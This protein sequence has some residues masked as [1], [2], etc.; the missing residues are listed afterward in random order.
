MRQG[1]EKVPGAGK[2]MTEGCGREGGSLEGCD[3]SWRWRPAGGGG[4][5]HGVDTRGGGRLVLRVMSCRGGVSGSHSRS[6]SG[7]WPTSWVARAGWWGGAG[8][9]PALTLSLL[10]PARPA[11]GPSPPAAKV[12]HRDLKPKNILANSD[13]KLKIC[14]EAAGQTG[15]RE[16]GQGGAAGRTRAGRAAA[17]QALRVSSRSPPTAPSPP[18]PFSLLPSAPRLPLCSPCRLWSGAPRLQRHAHHRVLDRLRGHP[19]VPRA[20]A[21]RLLLRQVLARHRHLV[22]GLHLCRGAAGQA[23]V[24]G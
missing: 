8:G 12:F 7:V 17:G 5:E 21:V 16:G 15:H 4:L 22:R 24:P 14:G 11:P 18:N 9:A 19:L 3:W 10:L 23:A 6:S 13:C 2:G 20:R 1:T